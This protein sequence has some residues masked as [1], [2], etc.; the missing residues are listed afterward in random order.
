MHE[1]TVERMRRIVQVLDMC[2]EG[3]NSLYQSTDEV[4]R[5][6]AACSRSGWDILPDQLFWREP[7]DELGNEI[8]DRGFLFDLARTYGPAPFVLALI[9]DHCRI[10]LRWG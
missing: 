3:V 6:L 8:L 5:A 2:H 7:E 9:D 10:N 1:T 4:Y